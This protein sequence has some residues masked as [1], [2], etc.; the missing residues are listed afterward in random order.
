MPTDEKKPASG[1]GAAMKFFGKLQGQTLTGFRDEWNSL[2]A[3]DQAQLTK[4][5]QDGTF[6]Y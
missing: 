1:I 4:G 6:T 2:S 3:A 5:I